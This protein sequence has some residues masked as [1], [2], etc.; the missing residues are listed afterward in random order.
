M[1]CFWVCEHPESSATPRRPFPQRQKPSATPRRPFPKRQKSSATLRNPFSE[2]RKSPAT[3]RRPF[4]KRQ[5]SSATLRNPFSE[6]RKSSATPRRPFPAASQG[7]AT[8]RRT[9]PGLRRH[10]PVFGMRKK[11]KNSLVPRY[12]PLL[13]STDLAAGETIGLTNAVHIC[14]QTGGR[15]RLP[16]KDYSVTV[17]SVG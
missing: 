7:S 14:E 16:E 5:K 15:A 13:L 17:L 2:R 8:P 12:T 10:A 6:R 1:L 9:L 11:I 4:P 3:P